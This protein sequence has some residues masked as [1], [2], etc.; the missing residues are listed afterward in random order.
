MQLIELHAFACD[1]VCIYLSELFDFLKVCILHVVALLAL[2][3]TGLL[4]TGIS[5]ALCT[6]TTLCAALG[7]HL[8]TGGLEG[9]VQFGHG[10]F[11]S[12]MALSM[13]A[14]S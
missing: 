12:A 7:I 9:C 2:V 5:I 11:S 6:G 3:T 14:R 13:A 8:S 4:A 1:L 10:V